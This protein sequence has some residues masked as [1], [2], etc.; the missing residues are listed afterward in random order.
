MH[1]LSN[2]SSAWIRPG[3]HIRSL[4]SALFDVDGVLIDVRR[5][6]RLA[7]M[8]GTDHLVRVVNGLSEA[9]TPLLAPEDLAAFKLAGGFNSDWDLTRLLAALWTARL[10]EWRDQPEAAI[11]LAEWA[12][13]A[14]DAARAGHGGVAWMLATFPAT[15]IPD[16]DTARW[17]HDEFYWGAALAHEHYGHE[18]RFAPDAPGLVHNEVL[19][20][21][22]TLLPA[23][24]VRGITRFGLITGR[25]GAEVGWAVRH[26]SGGAGLPE[27]VAPSGPWYDSA[28]GRSPFATIVP[29]TIYA[30]PDPSALVYAVQ[31]LGTRAGLFVGD[32][33][34]DLDLVLRYERESRTTDSALPPILSVMIATGTAAR[35]YRERGADIIIEHIRDLPAALDL[36]DVAEQEPTG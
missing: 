13:R 32:S 15:A 16:A 31:A 30:K 7:V 26:I 17:A 34:D 35:T 12:R 14:T 23:L 10:R 33:A 25:E 27:G 22:E 6:Y 8:A 3:L 18:P 1:S 29:A 36:L 4:D 28:H 11:S 2:M 20:L 5:S 24:R 19:L 21:D 9:P